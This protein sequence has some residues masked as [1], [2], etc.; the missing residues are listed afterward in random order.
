MTA[1]DIFVGIDISKS[2][3]DVAIT[4]GDQSFTCPNNEAG[5]QKLVR[6]LQRLNP[7]TILL[8]ATGGYE[9]LLVAA[10][11]E[12]ELPAC[13]IN[14]KLVRNFARGAGI[15]AKTDRLDAQVLALYASRMR[16]QPRPLPAAQQQ[17]LKYLLTRRRQLMDMIQMDK[18][19]LDPTPLPRIAQ[20][21]QQTIKS[22]ED[23]L[24]AL[25]REIDDFFQQHPL[26][27]EL[28]QT[29]TSALGIGHLTALILIAYLPEL[30]RLNHKKI[31]AL[32]G[33]APFNR[34][35]GQWRGHRHIEGGRSQLR[36]ALYMPTLVATQRDP[37]IQ[38]YY[39]RLLARGKAKKVALIACMRKLLT[40]LNAMVRK[41]QPWCSLAPL[42]P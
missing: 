3:L 16:P 12:A 27:L 31:A 17:E 5:I 20:S 26:W 8:E 4:P 19:R 32:A 11:R 37:V 29:L 36:K 24:T 40:I 18:N 14:P 7:Q 21:I 33:V 22:L 15:A 25:N 28:E 41:Q 9:F 39:Q 34:D 23:Q 38:A 35:S 42:T 10:L 30:G 6:R 13:F 1:S 2:R